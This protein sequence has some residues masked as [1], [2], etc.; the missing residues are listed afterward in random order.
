MGSARR[1][2]Y[3]NIFNGSEFFF[4]FFSFFEKECL[5]K[6]GNALLNALQSDIEHLFR[7][8]IKRKEKGGGN[9]GIIVCVT[10]R[11]KSMKI[12]FY[13]MKFLC[14]QR[15]NCLNSTDISVG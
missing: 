7:E 6:F 1:D 2:N 9:A 14:T 13:L 5:L 10:G 4:F 8:G 12:I 15:N 11:I 3:F